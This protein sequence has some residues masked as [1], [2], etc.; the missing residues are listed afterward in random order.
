MENISPHISYAEA[1]VSAT[2]KARSIKNIPT[3]DVLVRMKLVANKV[4]EPLRLWGGGPLFVSSF[5][6]SPKLNVSIGGSATSS[7]PKGEAIDVDGDVYPTKTN[8]QIFEYIRDNLKFDQLI[9][10]GIV[11]GRISWVHVSYKS[12]G[13]RNEILFM[14]VDKTGKTVYEKYSTKRYKELVK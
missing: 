1:T 11:G 9:I 5:Y 10:E 13:N 14:Y 12:S 7:H 6:R 3:A 2:A 4:F 8:K